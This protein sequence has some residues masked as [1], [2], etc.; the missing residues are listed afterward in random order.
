M[1]RPMLVDSR[2]ILILLGILNRTPLNFRDN[3][4]SVRSFIP[5]SSQLVAF[6]AERLRGLNLKEIIEPG[7]EE[8]SRLLDDGFVGHEHLP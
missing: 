8:R 7:P 2:K 5:Q 6:I 3:A 1:L 4:L